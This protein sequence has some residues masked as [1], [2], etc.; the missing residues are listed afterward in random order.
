MTNAPPSGRRPHL[1]CLCVGKKVHRVHKGL[2]YC[3][4]CY[5]RLFKRRLCPGCGN[6]ARLPIPDLDEKAVCRRCEAAAPCVRCRKVGKPVGLITEFGPACNSCAHYYHDPEP[7]EKCGELS[8]RL[9]RVLAID[10]D[11]RC[12][13]KCAREGAATCPDC[14]RHRFLIDGPDGRKR[15]KLCIEKGESLCQTCEKPMP[16]GRG[17]EC[18]DCTWEKSFNARAR[19]LVESFEHSPTRQRFSDFCQWLKAEMGAHPAALKLKNYLGFFAF[20]DKDPG[21]IPSYLSL[22]EHYAAD[23]LRRMQTPMLWL[24]VRYGVVPDPVMREDHSDRRRI[25]QM[26]DSIPAGVAADALTGY[27]SYLQSKQAEG[28]ISIRSVRGSLRAA[29]NVLAATSSAFDALPTQKSVTAYLTHTPGQAAALQGFIGYLNRSNDSNLT[30]EVDEVAAARARTHALEAKLLSL[31]KSAGEGDA[32]ERTWI[33][34]ALM[35]FHG[36]ASVNKKTLVYRT[37]VFQDRP[38]FTVTLKSKKYWVPSA[39]DRSTAVT[40]EKLN[41]TSE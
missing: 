11:L 12:C 6:H 21:G 38:G 2:P 28:R 25:E 16:A 15:C 39:A 24:K 7:C 27:R 31:Y 22:L 17:K 35:L 23:G 1:Q 30:N 37:E 8:T 9:T 13:P 33:K 4:T 41:S 36:V 18:D 3:S 32:F 20:L 26:L 14:R 29:A 34:T 19:I 10:P 5:A 40:F